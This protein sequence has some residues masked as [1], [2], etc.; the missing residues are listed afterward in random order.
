MK[1]QPKPSSRPSRKAIE[2]PAKRCDDDQAAINHAL[3]EAQHELQQL[4]VLQALERERRVLSELLLKKAKH[5]SATRA[6]ALAAFFVG[7]KVHVSGIVLKHA[8]FEG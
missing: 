4:L 8:V 6:C 7:P 5:E 1:P 2:S 3:Q